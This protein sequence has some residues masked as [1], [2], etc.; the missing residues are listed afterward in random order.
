MRCLMREMRQSEVV[1]MSW[2]KES[3]VVYP[4]YSRSAGEGGRGEEG[5]S[6]FL[7]AGGAAGAAG[8][9]GEGVGGGGLA[10]EEE[11]ELDGGAGFLGVLALEG[12]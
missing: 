5:G 8:L 1:T 4:S 10:L 3:E 2:E 12:E 6:V 11:E 9:G 7:E